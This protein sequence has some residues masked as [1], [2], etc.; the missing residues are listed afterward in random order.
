MCGIGGI[1]NRQP[2]SKNF[3]KQLAEMSRVLQHR[4]PDGEGFFAASSTSNN[5]YYLSLQPAASSGLPWLPKALLPEDLS[6]AKLMF[7]HRRLSII[8]LSAGGHQPMCNA[9]TTVWL[10]FNGELYNYIELKKELQ[11]KG[12]TFFTQSDSEVL[13]AAYLEWGTDCP[14][15]F[16]GMWAFCIYDSRN[17]TCFASRDRLGVKPFYFCETEHFFA[18]ASEQKALVKSGL[19]AAKASESAMA[20]FLLDGAL[21]REPQNF[22]EGI[23][24]LFPGSNLIYNVNTHQFK[25][26]QYYNLREHISSEN[27]P[28][29][30]KTLS[31][32]IWEKLDNAVQ[33]RL[34]SDVEVGTCLSGGIDSS[35]L[36][37]TMERHSLKPIHCFTAVFKS[38]SF[39]EEGFAESVALKIR[40][41]HHKTEPTLPEFLRDIDDLI[42]SQDVPIWSSSTYAQYRVMQL[43]KKN[44]IKVVL[45]GQGA[46]ELFAGYHHHFIAHWDALRAEKKYKVL[47]KELFT[48]GKSISLPFV[49]YAKQLLKRKL[50][51]DK[52]LESFFAAK[53]IASKSNNS[54]SNC[55]GV[56]AQLLDDIYVSRL[57]I[58]LKCEDRAGMWHSVE[59]RTPFSDDVHLIE[60]A[61]SFNGERKL[62]NGISKYHL[63]EA[64]KPFLPEEIYT[65]YDKIG[66][67][68]PMKKWVIEA[69]DMMR[70]EILD[71]NFSFITPAAIQKI[72]LNNTKQNALFFR[73]FAL[74]RWKKIFEA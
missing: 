47:F 25:T 26:Q 52:Q 34:R 11:Q 29:S 9:D 57:K 50:R 16:N 8:D 64:V 36:A 31:S 53:F 71:A 14:S 27:E 59:S 65:R 58:F 15:H 20:D 7:L 39:N 67:E 40:A 21:E 5:S 18:F 1:I 70:K 42:Y 3:S 60:A 62:K 45:D 46:D 23:V 43:A 13:I 28:L 35:A 19:I 73:L 72:Q 54:Q 68:T 33:L 61:F 37:V 49:F 4:G 41:Q 22:F 55:I 56:N 66:F 74:A 51:P 24:E 17:N 6:A 38:D 48:I 30:D 69:Q 10:T 32:L 2:G 63:R 12:H 44:G